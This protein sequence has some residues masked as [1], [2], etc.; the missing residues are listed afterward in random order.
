M[1]SKFLFLIAALSLFSPHAFGQTGGNFTITGSV[2]ASGG[3][4]NTA[5]GVFSLDGTTG[6]S[7][8]GSASGAPFAVTAGF[9]NLAPFAPSA[10]AASISGR[11]LTSGG[12]GIRS[13]TISLTGTTSG[14]IR[15]AR[16]TNFGYYRFENVPVGETYVLT[17]RAK[18]FVF[19]PETRVVTLLDELTDVD[20]T[21]VP[22]E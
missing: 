16:S 11:V 21:A 4:Q 18:R 12:R 8:A 10:A 2:I 6:Q 15:S 22:Q 14:E 5:G 1:N 13:V 17:V 7:A 9:W 20:F 19:L 3:G